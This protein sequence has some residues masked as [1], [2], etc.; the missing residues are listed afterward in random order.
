MK[1]H[2]SIKKSGLLLGCSLLLTLSS[3]HD[4]K[5]KI[6][7]IIKPV[8]ENPTVG[9]MSASEQKKKIDTIGQNF[10]DEIN[11]ADF[12]YFSNLS[13]FV[14]SDLDDYDDELIS[15]WFEELIDQMSVK[16][17]TTV[18]TE[19]SYYYV[20]TYY[21]TNYTQLIILS[22]FTGHFVAEN[23]KWNYAK[24]S[25]L[26]FS[27]KDQEGK[28]ATLTVKT[29]GSYKDVHIGEDEDWDD[30]NYLG[31]IGGKYYDD[32]YI[33]VYDQTVRVPSK[34]VAT[35][36]QGSLVK[37]QLEVNI[38]LSGMKAEDYN[39]ATD[40]YS[41]DA[42]LKVGNYT[43]KNAKAAYNGKSNAGI[44]ASLHK[45]S[46]VLLIMSATA[47]GNYSQETVKEVNLGIDILGEL[48]I[49]GSVA[50]GKEF[51]DYVD[52]AEKYSENESKYKSNI[53]LAN[54]LLNLGVYYDGNDVR[55]AKIMLE[56]FN[57]QDR[58][59]NYWYC[60]PVF[61][62]GEESSYSSFDAF[63]DSGFDKLISRF[64]KIV[65]DFDRLFD[66]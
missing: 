55:Q 64:E 40:S 43:V 2:I 32:I 59:S 1:K 27:F 17:K 13:E 33:N 44:T 7:D 20:D 53:A 54:D 39:L 23:Y 6:D 60:E 63:F 47:D 9:K 4:D 15:H 14:D 50:N 48:Q 45:G 52:K 57:E 16:G 26:Q 8:P 66:L 56:C 49:R 24:A 28:Q 58:W 38:D 42:E 46:K 11:S 37:S 41:A 25:D 31:Y 22:N 34:I 51:F 5:E 21:Y 10:L 3:C 35:L 65:D 61:Y 30:Y 36:K 12:K 19:E 18:E 29:S 62:F